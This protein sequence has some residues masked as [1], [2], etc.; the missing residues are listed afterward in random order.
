MYY[1]FLLSVY[2]FNNL[3]I[4]AFFTGTI[5]ESIFLRQNVKSSLS[6]VIKENN[7][8][9]EK[10]IEKLISTNSVKCSV[11]KKRIKIEEESILKDESIHN[12]KKGRDK[13]E[14]ENKYKNEN[15]NEIVSEG[16]RT[17]SRISLPRI[18]KVE[19]RNKNKNYEEDYY[20][21]ED[22]KDGRGRRD[23]EG[24]EGEEEEK[25]EEGGSDSEIGRAHV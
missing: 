14:R 17:S 23:E 1:H 21:E 15:E 6:V 11:E 7:D 3:F 4:F 2:L 16:S 13:L 25:E 5:E 19:K 8:N 12:K 20:D 22:E 9:E 10:D 24:E 18:S